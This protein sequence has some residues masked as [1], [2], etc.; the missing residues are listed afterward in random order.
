MP[1]TE[2]LRMLSSLMPGLKSW[3]SESQGKELPQL[4]EAYSDTVDLYKSNFINP[5]RVLT[6]VEYA[7]YWGNWAF[8]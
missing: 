2:P 6:I 8:E 5:K 3:W 1:M 7:R 4:M